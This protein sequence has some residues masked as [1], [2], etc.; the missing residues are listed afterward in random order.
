LEAFLA[1][2]PLDCWLA[3]SSAC[4]CCAYRHPKTGRTVWI[5][6]EA[7]HESWLL[8]VGSQE[9]RKKE[10]EVRRLVERGVP[11]SFE[12][13]LKR[14]DKIGAT[15]HRRKEVPRGPM[16]P[17]M[18]FFLSESLGIEMQSCSHPARLADYLANKATRG[19][20][21]KMWLEDWEKGDYLFPAELVADPELC[22]PLEEANRLFGIHMTREAIEPWLTLK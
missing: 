16:S 8:I 10:A 7:E 2:I 4:G 14:Y 3:W 1:E 20:T 5:A 6:C 19:L 13:T 12:F 22:L 9:L 15:F 21:E 11:R 18:C 17:E